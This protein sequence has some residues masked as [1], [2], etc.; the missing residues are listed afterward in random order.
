MLTSLIEEYPFI[1]YV[2]AFAAIFQ[3]IYFIWIGLD[4]LDKY[5]TE[6]PVENDAKKIQ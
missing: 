4:V 3:V 1:N 5:S 6:G 2:L